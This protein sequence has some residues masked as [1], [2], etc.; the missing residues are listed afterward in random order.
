MKTFITSLKTIS[1]LL[2]ILTLLQSCVVYN[3]SLYNLDQTVETSKETKNFSQSKI[4]YKDGTTQKCFKVVR[5]QSNYYCEKR[6]QKMFKVD[7]TRDLID[8]DQ[9]NFVKT[10]NKEKTLVV[11]IFVVTAASAGLI[12]LIGQAFTNSFANAL[13]DSF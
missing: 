10:Q 12:Y 4:F 7:Y 1:I 5:E 13:V 9:V 2:A 3:R 11:G 8:K 6:K